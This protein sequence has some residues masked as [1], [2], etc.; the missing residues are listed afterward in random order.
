MNTGASE[1]IESG[2]SVE[3]MN[4]D[5]HGAR[6]AGVGWGAVVACVICGLLVGL[7]AYWFTHRGPSATASV[8]AAPIV[9]NPY[10]PSSDN[11]ANLKTE[12]ELVT[13]DP[14]TAAVAS[15]LGQQG[16]ESQLAKKTDATAVTGSQV[17]RITVEANN[18]TEARARAQAFA[19]AYLAERKARA[20]R[21]ID[22]RSI[23][24]TE[25]VQA[26]EKDLRVAAAA[27]A[28]AKSG[29]TAHELAQ[30]QVNVASTAL[31]SRTDDLSALSTTT[32]QPGEQI[33]LTSTTGSSGPWALAI[34]GALIGLLV[35]LSLHF[36]VGARGLD[37]REA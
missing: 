31:A 13:A 17:I 3:D 37:D 25:A 32:T 12:A 29:T 23:N 10:S 26:A 22:E 8:L 11:L 14:V 21:A 15:S 36:L 34:G 5:V 27:L 7:G 4:V 19:D 20:E 6:R 2:K 33:G 9:G 35:G 1:S 24:L 28:K 16:F 30:Q 18:R